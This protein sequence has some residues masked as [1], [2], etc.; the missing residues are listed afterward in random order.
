MLHGFLVSYASGEPWLRDGRSMAQRCR[1]IQRAGAAGAKG[2]GLLG[3]AGRY[4]W[5]NVS[6][7]K[8]RYSEESKSDAMF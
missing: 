8:G 5:R 6:A 7:K 4:F 1:I 2:N 3:K